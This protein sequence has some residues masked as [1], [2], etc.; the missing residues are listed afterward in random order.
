MASVLIRLVC[1]QMDSQVCLDNVSCTFCRGDLQKD[2]QTERNLARDRQQKIAELNAVSFNLI[3]FNMQFYYC[4][5][6]LLM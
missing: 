1:F 5:Y 3:N 6:I 2:F 4:I